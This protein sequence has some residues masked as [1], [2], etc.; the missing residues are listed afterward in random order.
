M[1]E[2]TEKEVR[3]SMGK[4][5]VKTAK[6]EIT[7]RYEAMS[8]RNKA[9]KENDVFGKACELAGIP[10]TD[11]QASKWNNGKGK[12]LSMRKKAAEALK[13]STN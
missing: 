12:A 4:G 1:S 3:Q 6:S 5:K 9:V 8:V 13:T 7:K 2:D 10:V 11:R